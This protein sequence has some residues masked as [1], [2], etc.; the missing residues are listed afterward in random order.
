MLTP[1]YSCVVQQPV[2]DVQQ[3]VSG[4]EGSVSLQV[5]Y[6]NLSP[7]GQWVNNPDYGYVWIP[8]AG[9]DFAPYSTAGYWIMTDYGWMWLSDYE[10]GWAP[11]HYGRWD[12]D[13]Y[14]GWFW[15]PGLEWGPAWVVWRMGEGYYGWAPMRPGISI[16]MSFRSNYD[17]NGWIFVR[18]RDFGRQNLG[19]YYIDRGNNDRIIRNSTV[20]NN[21][22][23]DNSRRVTYVAG[24][25]PNEV[26]LATGRSIRHIAVRDNDRPGQKF[27]NNQVQLYRPRAESGNETRTKSAPSRVVDV[28]DVNTHAGRNFSG[29]YRSDQSHAQPQI[30]QPK[31][32]EPH[33]NQQMDPHDQQKG[34]SHKEPQIQN[35][36]QRQQSRQEA[37]D[38]KTLM[39]HQ[40][41]AEKN[42]QDK[43]DKKENNNR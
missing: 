35:F 24:P 20:I 16:E 3:Q 25:S 41:R 8:D 22:Y 36:H 2:S 30:K 9:P 10:W 40:N 37:R 43:D 12:Y 6:D 15:I 39:R 17:L 33:E 26:Q 28:K 38:S 7:Y 11:F 32:M 5:F 13:N 19:R 23:T 31:S 29:L 21:T 42:V 1:G 18:D 27:N 14:L 34:D 4:Q